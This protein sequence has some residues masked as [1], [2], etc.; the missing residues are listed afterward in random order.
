[1]PRSGKGTIGRVCEALLG[2][3]NVVGL[4]LATLGGRFGL[5]SLM[6]KSLAIVP[7]AHLG[8]GSDRS[9]ITERLLSTSGEDTQTIERKHLPSVTTRLAV[10]FMMLA[11]Q[12]P[13]L[14]NL[15]GALASRLLLLRLENSWVGKEDPRLIDSLLAEM[16]GILL[17]ALE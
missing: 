4:G 10:R 9:W 8:T 15:S 12:I 7:D 11:N 2:R 17:W 1:P 5:A 13:S 6:G 3:D 16:P 14:D